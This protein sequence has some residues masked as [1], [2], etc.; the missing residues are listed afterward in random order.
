[1]SINILSD[2]LVGCSLLGLYWLIFKTKCVSN[3]DTS[4]LMDRGAYMSEAR[5]WRNNPLCALDG[6]QDKA[7]AGFTPGEDCKVS[8]YRGH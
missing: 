2:Y 5:C 6:G 4:G 3:R 1:M 7:A 8:S